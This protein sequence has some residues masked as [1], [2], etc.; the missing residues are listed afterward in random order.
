MAPAAAAIADALKLDLAA[1]LATGLAFARV[2]PSCRFCHRRPL[3]S[4][5]ASR[6]C[7]SPR[8]V[9]IHVVA[10]EPE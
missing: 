10:A 7:R 1:A 4:W 3:R 8:A 9:L 5:L 2:R 6:H